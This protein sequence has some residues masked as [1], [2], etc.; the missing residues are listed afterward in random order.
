M[1]Y[2]QIIGSGDSWIDSDSFK[3]YDSGSSSANWSRS[4]T[5]TETETEA[6][7]ETETEKGCETLQDRMS[8]VG[9]M[10][11]SRPRAM[12]RRDR[13]A[14]VNPARSRSFTRAPGACRLS[15]NFAE[16]SRRLDH[17]KKADRSPPHA[18]RLTEL[19]LSQ[20]RSRDGVPAVLRRQDPRSRP[21]HARTLCLGLR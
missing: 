16:R 11:D 9:W 17:A 2:C 8:P 1:F 19:P 5:E 20:S 10:M 6:E 7:T 21:T 12:N 18:S 3:G 14:C 15:K 4:P 13:A